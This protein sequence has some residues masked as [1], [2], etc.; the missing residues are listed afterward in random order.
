VRLAWEDSAGAASWSAERPLAVEAD[1]RAVR[2][3]MTPALFAAQAAHNLRARD[4]VTEVNALAARVRQA[5]RAAP[6]GADT[7]ALGALERAVLAE[8]VR[9]GRPGLQT[10][11]QYLYGAAL[12]AD[13]PVGR[14]VLARYAELRREVDARRREADRL[15]GP[16][17][18]AR[19]GR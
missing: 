3:G 9:Y 18:T 10:Q 17:A 1:P 8:P 4:L 13:Q 15:L 12:G 6:A 2:D 14:D 11:V 16:A 19:G 5:R 7:A